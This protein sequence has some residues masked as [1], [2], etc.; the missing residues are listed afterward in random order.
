MVWASALLP[1]LVLLRVTGHADVFWC[2]FAWGAAATVAAAV[3]PLQA[4]VVPRLSGARGWLSRHRDLGP[5][6]L[7][8]STS[9]SGAYQ[10]RTYG[11]GLIV[12]LAAVGYV[13]A[14]NTLM[15]PFLVLFMGMGLVIVPEAARVL[16]R[17][18]RHVQPF[19]LLVGGGLALA[20]LGWGVLLLVALPRGLG[21]RLLGPL[22]RP[23]YPL[24]LPLT[25]SIMGT[26]AS[27]RRRRGPARSG[28]R[29][30]QRAGGRPRGGHLSRLW[31]GRGCCRR[32]SRVG[33]RL[34]RCDMDCRA[35]VVVAAAR[36]TA[37]GRPC[38][39]A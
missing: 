22:W 4:R 17:S 6:Y 38:T 2:V 3:G 24:V 11:I 21:D 18:P 10:L 28:G 25:L 5:R 13:Q 23:T 20:A 31:S 19:C 7:V 1:A 8:E 29:A 37:G 16:R 15:G 27:R 30:A 36:G 33:A 9:C 34:R 32:S 39:S 26:C 12:G 14:A 35:A